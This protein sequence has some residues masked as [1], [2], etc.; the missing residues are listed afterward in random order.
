MKELVLFN[1]GNKFEL[2]TD[3][4]MSSLTDLWKAAGSDKQKT[5]AKWQ[6]SEPVQRFIKAASRML[7]IGDSDIIKTKKGKGGGTWAHSQIALEYAQYLD[8]KLAVL[9]NQVFFERIEEEKNPD[10]IVDRAIKTYGNKGKSAEWI[11]KRLEGKGKRNEF[12]SALAKHGVER[13]GFRNCTNAIYTPLWGGG[14][15]VVRMKKGLTKTDSIRDNL[16]GIELEAL[17]FAEAL[18][19]NR[20]DKFNL[21]GN[22]QC[23]EASLR[24]SISVRDALKTALH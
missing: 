19:A 17:K 9:V 3:G 23:E 16:T 10:L 20:I 18:A 14:S 8:P 6:E 12:T 11:S 7:N 15:N 1:E 4:N 21:T 5:P 2:R 22:A 24:A 13:E